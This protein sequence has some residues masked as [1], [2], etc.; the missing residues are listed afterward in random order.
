VAG[1]LRSPAYAC[2]DVELA[3]YRL[4]GGSFSYLW[5]DL[6]LKAGRVAD[7]LRDLR[8]LHAK[9]HQGSLAA[10][11]EE[12]VAGSRLVEAGLYVSADRNAF[13]RARFVI[14]QARLFEAEGPESL[15]AFVSWLEQRAGD[16]ILDHEGAGLDDDEDAVRILTVHAAKGLEFPI[17]FLAGLGVSPMNQSATLLV[18]RRTEAIGVSIGANVRNFTAGPIGDINAQERQH[19]EAERDRLL[20]V[21]ATRARDHLVV[22]LYRAEKSRRTAAERLLDAGGAGMAAPQLPELPEV[23]DASLQPFAGLQVDA[24]DGDEAAFVAARQRLARDAKQE[25]VTSATALG[26]LLRDHNEEQDEQKEREDETEPWARGRAGTHRG[27]AVHAALQVLPWDAGVATIEALARAQSVAEAV[28]EDAGAIQEL[29]RRAL[30]TGAASRARAARRSL[31]EVPFA[32]FEEGVTLEGFIDL[33]VEDMDGGL[34][35]IDWKTDAVAPSEVGRRLESYR[36]QAGL[37]VLGLEAATGRP[38]Q[39]V[40]YVFVTPGVEASPGEPPELAGYAREQ[41]RRHP[42]RR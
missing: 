28:P 25:I 42:E 31:R 7:S 30:E 18:D 5:P 36:L 38:V 14:E 8:R 17:V 16:A 39:R 3:E 2:S 4:D 15:R 21:A 13:R 34:E 12:F 26:Q 9:R 24:A 41:L 6:D 37:Y 29:L 20:Y 35:V 10:L 22:S 32:L 19:Q 11:V 27:R 1:A 33:V 40:T 23:R